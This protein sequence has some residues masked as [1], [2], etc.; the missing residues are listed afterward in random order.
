MLIVSSF[1]LLTIRSWSKKCWFSIRS[2][3]K[4]RKTC[5]F[6]VSQRPWWKT[7][8]WNPHR[9]TMFLK[10]DLGPRRLVLAQ[11]IIYIYTYIHTYIHICIYTYQNVYMYIT[12]LSI[13]ILYIYIYTS[14]S[15]IYIYIFKKIHWDVISICYQWI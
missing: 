5:F 13:M 15:D 4:L 3:A 9:A 10:V 7:M 8:G 12:F 14:D 6:L 11:L 1:W 2:V